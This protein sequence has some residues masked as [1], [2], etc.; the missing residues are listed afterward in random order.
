MSHYS[1]TVSAVK[2]AL[3]P[4]V[5]L[6][7]RTQKLEQFCYLLDLKGVMPRSLGG[8]MDGVV[9]L[10]VQCTLLRCNTVDGIRHA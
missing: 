9:I 10:T 6:L 8:K 3:R 7:L 5:G 4:L 1:E 2:K